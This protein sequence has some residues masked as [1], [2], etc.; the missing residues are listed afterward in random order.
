MRGLLPPKA[1]RAEAAAAS[2]RVLHPSLG[3][4]LECTDRVWSREQSSPLE[5]KG[6][7]AQYASLF[8]P[9]QGS[10]ILLLLFCFFL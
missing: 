5:M 8:S 2:R 3:L 6:C 4:A 9:F 7:G 1:P 10:F